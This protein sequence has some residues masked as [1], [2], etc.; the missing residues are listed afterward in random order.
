M[1]VAERREPF[2]DL[3]VAE[4][5]GR[6]AA[7]AE[8][9]SY[10]DAQHHGRGAGGSPARRVAAQLDVR[11]PHGAAFYHHFKGLAQTWLSVKLPRQ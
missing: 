2:M 9:E 8:P 10:R 1:Q 6:K 3:V 4:A 11:L 5:L 7:Q